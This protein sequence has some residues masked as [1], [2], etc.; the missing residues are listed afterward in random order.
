MSKKKKKESSPADAHKDYVPV[1]FAHDNLE[2]EQ[3]RDLLV[4][5]EI[6]AVLGPTTTGDEDEP[7]GEGV[8]VLVPEAYLD[9]ASEVIAENEDLDAF[10]VEDDELFNE[11]DEDGEDGDG[12]ED[13][14]EDDEEEEEDEFLDDEEFE[15]EEEEEEEEFDDEE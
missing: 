14:D 2:A 7:I 15:D 6:P 8:P 1:V 5:N 11:D 3:Y 12:D 4:E 9:Q 13:E 10:D